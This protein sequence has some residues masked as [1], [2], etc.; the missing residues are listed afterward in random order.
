MATI[1]RLATEKDVPRIERLL[2]KANVHASGVD[3]PGTTFL[4]VESQKR[5]TSQLIGTAGVELYG[6][7][8]LL[9]SLVVDSGAGNARIGVEVMRVLLAFVQEQGVQELYLLTRMP[10]L[11]F[12]PLGFSKIDRDALPDDIKMSTHVQDSGSEAVTMVHWLG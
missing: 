9:R 12:E 11:F 2:K 5:D 8:A 4:V 6:K 7:K 10:S 3:K 1:V